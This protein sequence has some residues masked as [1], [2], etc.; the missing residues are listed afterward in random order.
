MQIYSIYSIWYLGHTQNPD[1]FWSG[2]NTQKKNWLQMFV[3][4][5]DLT[6][7]QQAIFDISYFMEMSVKPNGNQLCYKKFKIQCFKFL[8]LFFFIA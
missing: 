8:V 7:F 5:K 2:C 6:G 1:K 4:Y 3:W